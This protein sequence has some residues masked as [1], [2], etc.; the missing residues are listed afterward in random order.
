MVTRAK[1]SEPCREIE[2]AILRIQFN[3]AL[4]AS[5]RVTPTPLSAIN[6]SAHFK[7]TRIVWDRALSNGELVPRAVVIE[8]AVVSV[9]SRDEVCVARISVQSKSRINCRFRQVQTA[10]RVIDPREVELVVGPGQ[11]AISQKKSR[12]SRNCLVE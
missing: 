3:C 6:E 4:E 2:I 1:V 9:Q 5:R 8:V 11:L 10:R 7:D 12:V